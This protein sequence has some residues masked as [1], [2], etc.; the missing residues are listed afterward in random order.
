MFQ[1]NFDYPQAKVFGWLKQSWCAGLACRLLWLPT[2]TQLFCA[3]CF[4]S[5]LLNHCSC[6]HCPGETHRCLPGAH[7]AWWKSRRA[8]HF[9]RV[10]LKNVPVRDYTARQALRLGK[11]SLA[12]LSPRQLS[13]VHCTLVFFL[14]LRNQTS[15]QIAFWCSELSC[16][17]ADQHHIRN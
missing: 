8:P 14:H 3:A 13:E 12:L 7:K 16:G 9:P 6:C 10:P 4:P 11:H 17:L 2:L 5:L 1:K 15:I